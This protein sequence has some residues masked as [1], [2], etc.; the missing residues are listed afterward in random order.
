MSFLFPALFC[1]CESAVLSF[2]LS[3]GVTRVT[4]DCFLPFPLKAGLIFFLLRGLF[5]GNWPRENVVGLGSA[6]EERTEGVVL[7]AK[8]ERERK[9]LFTVF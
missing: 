8:R 7:F 4:R 6:D 1:L 3:C 2:S 5:L 9:F